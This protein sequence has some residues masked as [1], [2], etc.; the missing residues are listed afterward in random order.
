MAWISIKKLRAKTTLGVNKFEQAILSDIDL[1]L[2]YKLELDKITQHDDLGY[3]I[4]YANLS[5]NISEWLSIQKTNLLETLAANL[6]E[7]IC[8]QYSI[9]SIKLSVT[10]IRAIDNKTDVTISLEKNLNQP[11]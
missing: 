9:K 6:L 4:D 10:K 3:T 5:S 1:D 8:D 11:S 7:Y 2:S